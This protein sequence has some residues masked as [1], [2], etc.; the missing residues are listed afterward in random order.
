[1]EFVD[2]DHGQ[3]AAQGASG[4][5]MLDWMRQ[6][7][8]ITRS[9][10]GDGL[11]STLAF[12]SERVPGLR[13]HSVPSGFRVGDWTVPDEWNITEAYLE[14]SSGMHLVD[15][16]E[17]NLHVVG[18][19][20]PVD[21]WLT[22]EALEP[23]LYSIAE[24]P[25]A[26]PYVTSY[27][28]RRWGF[29]LSARSHE[30][31]GTGP[32]HAVIKSRIAPG[33][34]NFADL[35]IPGDSSDEVFLTTYVC[36]PSMANNE[37][38]GP[39]VTMAL[40]RWLLAQ[41]RRRYTYRLY[42]GPETIGAITYLQLF[43]E[44]L[45]SRVRAGWVITCVGDER[46]F[47]FLPSRRGGTLA[48][49]ASLLALEEGGMQFDS[50]QFTDRGS[51]ERQW[52]WPSIDLPVCSLMRSKYGTYPEYHTSLD[53]LEFVSAAGLSGSLALLTRAIGILEANEYPL[54][55]TLGEPQ[56]S[57]Y[58]LYP[59]IGTRHMSH[60]PGRS[61]L[62]LLSLSDGSRDLI[63]ISRAVGRPFGDVVQEISTLQELGLV[64]YLSKGRSEV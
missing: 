50:Y 17:C 3:W 6:L 24:L 34:L 33:E 4:E 62:E 16:A 51:D 8:P 11:R 55:T 54:A 60:N 57:R 52:C 44:H 53:N 2:D 10:T 43:G 9:I 12:I 42:W 32:F 47:S 26:I 29:C 63:E 38:S 25:D 40:A 21:E 18:Y 45:R 56:L 20:T 49:R 30:A 41:P 19:S 61:F 1:M 39:V 36:H 22:R 15:F 46:T 7:W 13:L 27:Y 64:E 5:Q 28:E 37:L 14:D 35:I 59:T 23:H 58:D 48:D 31:L